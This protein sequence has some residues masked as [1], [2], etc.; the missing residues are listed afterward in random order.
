MKQTVPSL[1]AT[2]S[3]VATPLENRLARTNATKWLRRFLACSIVF[4]ATAFHSHAGVALKLEYDG[5][6]GNT[7][8]NLTNDAS[9]PNSPT[10]Y[11]ALVN[12]LDRKS[13][14]L[15]SSHANISYAVFCLEN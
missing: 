1:V 15:N 2:S 6:T 5:I 4:T 13:T 14:R 8:S 10:T 3:S 12:G 9:F 7:V 11:D